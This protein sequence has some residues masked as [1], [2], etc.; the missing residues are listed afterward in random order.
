MLCLAISCT[1][2]L[3]VK[4]YLNLTS[5]LYCGLTAMSRTFCVFSVFFYFF[6]YFFAFLT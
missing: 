6:L 3:F 2:F 4:V 1:S 5:I